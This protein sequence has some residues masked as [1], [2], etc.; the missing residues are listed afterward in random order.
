MIDYA[1]WMPKFELELQ[2]TI[3]A[4]LFDQKLDSSTFRLQPALIG[5]LIQN[6]LF[7]VHVIHSLSQ[8]SN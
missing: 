2:V 5:V 4:Q 7:I 3:V 1:I 8:W 6:E